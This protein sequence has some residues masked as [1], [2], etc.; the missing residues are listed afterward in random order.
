M[1]R[2]QGF[3][4]RDGQVQ[5]GLIC[6]EKQAIDATLRSL[7][8]EDPRVGTVADRYWNARGGSHTDGG[9]FIFNLEDNGSPA[10]VKQLTCLDK[11]GKEVSVPSGQV[12]YL[13]GRVYYVLE[14]ENRQRFNIASFFEL[15]RP[16]ILFDSL[17]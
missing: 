8:D 2:P 12:P 15:Q 5:G 16:D 11:L 4:R 14:E 9:S 3:W 6:S 17:H 1:L 13:P 7:S 10:G